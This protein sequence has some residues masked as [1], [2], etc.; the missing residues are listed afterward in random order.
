MDQ[1]RT[2][3]DVR[4][5]FCM[6]TRS[7]PCGIII[8]GASGDLTYRKLIPALYNL[9]KRDLLPEDFFVLGCARTPMSNEEF[10]AKARESVKIADQSMLDAFIGRFSYCSGDYNDSKTY[11]S[12]SQKLDELDRIYATK[13]NRLFYF[14]IPPDFY[15]PIVNMLDSVGLVKEP[16]NSQNSIRVILEKPFGRNLESALSLDKELHF[17]LSERQI[18]RIDHYLGKET[19]Q[20][21]LM[22]RFANAVFEPIWNRRYIDHVQ[23]TVAETLGVEHRAGYFE[24]AGLLRD[25]FQNHILQMLALVAMEPP[26]SFNAD[27][28]R[29]ERVKLLRSLRPFQLDKLDKFIV[30]GQYTSGKSRGLDVPGYRQEKNIASDSP[31][32]TFVSAKVFVE[33]WRWQGVPFYIR[34]GKRLERKLSKIAIVFKRV[35]YSMFRPLPP[36]ELSPNVLVMNVQPEEG[37]SLTIQAK[38]PGAKLCMSSLTMNFRYKDI[39]G[40]EMPDA[41]ERLLLDCM[42]GDQT[43]FWRSDDVES[44]WSFVTPILD[45][46]ESEPESCPLTFYE[47]G[48]WGPRESAEL[49]ERDGREWR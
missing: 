3:I 12:I 16:D 45:K 29:D 2:E 10:Q 15:S 48:S 28:V 23:I 30:R 42:L 46:W 31:I 35:P 13:G 22:F 18:Y 43:L 14:A 49:I 11:I 33:N 5:G 32:E 24:R 41:Y 1:I 37:I 4:N 19:V 9:F 47:S 20:N 36:E 39:F 38:Q 34:T 44:A 7:G 40:I 8:F 17:V 25:M 27:R 6:E 26:T 21:I